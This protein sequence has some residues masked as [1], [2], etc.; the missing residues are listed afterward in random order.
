MPNHIIGLS[1]HK[2]IGGNS[3][4][5]KKNQILINIILLSYSG[6]YFYHSPKYR[7][8]SLGN[9]ICLS[10]IERAKELGY[11]Y[12]YFG[13]YVKGSISMEYKAAFAPNEVLADGQWIPFR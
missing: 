3:Y 11:E 7:S 9:W 10:M 13:Y 1:L 6:I 8:L 2:A 12:V 4:F 5:S